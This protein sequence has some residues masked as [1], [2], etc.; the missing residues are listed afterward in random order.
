MGTT[1]A[2]LSNGH[3]MT[4]QYEKGNLVLLLVTLR[5][6]SG[7]TTSVVAGCL[8][9]KH[10]EEDY[11]THRMHVDYR[12]TVNSSEK[13]CTEKQVRAMHAEALE[14]MASIFAE[15]DK[16]YEKLSK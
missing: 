9:E 15:C 8:V 16:H 3:K 11:L 4:T 13:R 2:K 7:L 6:M 12:C 5:R 1:Y 14:K 10:G